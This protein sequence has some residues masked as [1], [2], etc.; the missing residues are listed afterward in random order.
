M[1]EFV[2]LEVDGA[3]G[4]IRLDRPPMNALNVQVQEEIRAAALE[5]S[6]RPEIRAVVIYGGPRVFATRGASSTPRRRCASA[7]STRWRRPSSY[8]TRPTAG[9]SSS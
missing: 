5:A 6:E 1:A 4:T 7:S 2:T 8:T 3:V 9:P